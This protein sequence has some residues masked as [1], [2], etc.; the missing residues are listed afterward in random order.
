VAHRAREAAREPSFLDNLFD[1]MDQIGRSG[2]GGH[3]SGGFGSFNQMVEANEAACQKLQMKMNEE[4]DRNA[5][6]HE[7]ERRFGYYS[8]AAESARKWR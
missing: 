3:S 7:V 2:G 6:V 4:A 5:R 1:A 8:S